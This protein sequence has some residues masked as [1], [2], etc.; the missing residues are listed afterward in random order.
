MNQL[1]RPSTFAAMAV[2]VAAGLVIGGWLAAVTVQRAQRTAPIARNVTP[3]GPSVPAT[4]ARATPPPPTV[5]PATPAATTAA[6][7]TPAPATAVPATPAPATAAV[8]NA[9]HGAWRIDE[10]NVLVGT[11]VWSGAG[12]SAGRNTIALELRKAS[13]AGRA[14]SRCERNTTLRASVAAGVAGQTVPYE[15]VNCL[16][17]ASTGEVHVASFSS[18]GSSFRGS[19][20]QGGTNLGSFVAQRE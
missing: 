6:P 20:S 15:E 7:A 14:A 2:I 8:A 5:A 4:V 18:D 9:A 17:T 12:V 10:A 16:G 1:L 19:F 11:I 3:A 13:V